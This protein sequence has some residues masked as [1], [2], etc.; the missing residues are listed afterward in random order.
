MFFTIKDHHGIQT[1]VRSVE[2]ELCDADRCDL[3]HF[4]E[5]NCGIGNVDVDAVADIVLSSAIDIDCGEYVGSFKCSSF[6]E[7]TM[8]MDHE[9]CSDHQMSPSQM[10]SYIR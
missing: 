4:V 3:R 5:E 9:I 7:T 10:I 1:L 8:Q 2:E 6:R